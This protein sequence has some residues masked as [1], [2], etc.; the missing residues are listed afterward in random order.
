MFKELEIFR[1]KLYG[2][3][4]RSKAALFDLMDALLTTPA[5]PSLVQVSLSPL[6]RRQWSSAFK[7]I[8]NFRWNSNSLMRW[9]LQFV[10][11]G[12]GMLVMAL[13]H[14]P[15]ARL[16]AKTLKERTIE[17]QPTVVQGNKPITVGHGYSTLA[18]IPEMEGSWVL[19]LRHER[20]TSP[21]SSES[22][23][24]NERKRLKSPEGGMTK[25]REA[26]KTV[27]CVDT[28]SELYKDIFPEVRAYEAFK[29]IIT[30]ILSDIKRK[31]LPAIA[32]LLGLD[33][34]QGLLHFI[35]DSP[36]ELKKLEERRL[37]I[38]LEILE[39]R[40][41]M[42]IVDET[43]DRKKG[44]K[45][46]YVKR[47]YIGNVGKLDNGIVSVNVYGYID[48][49]TFPLKSKVYKPRE[50]LK[51]GDK[52]KTKPELAAEMIKELEESGFK[53]TRVLADSLY[54]ESQCNF[55]STADEL[56]IEYAV[57]IRSNHGVWLPKGARVR[58]N[59]WRRFDHKKWDGKLENSNHSGG[60]RN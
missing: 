13:D 34:E 54:G 12:E 18:V 15:W 60:G 25:A 9:L 52:Y 47:Q 32:S 26:K 6:F 10:V 55:I 22:E 33:N 49:V 53:I 19:P 3:L 46:D 14:T 43:G 28:Y 48:G 39:G 4:R 41:I 37:N 50:R 2:E 35:T 27:Q 29:Y 16:Y 7:A 44:S 24:Y 23:S 11:V 5:T 20:I 45:T 1:Q 56:E 38:I 31:S 58:T 36:W 17:H 8:E 57:S 42:A 21:L 40:G 30:G 59:K 51:E